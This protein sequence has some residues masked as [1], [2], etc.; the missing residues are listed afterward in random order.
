[1]LDMCSIIAHTPY[2]ILLNEEMCVLV[3]LF[4]RNLLNIYIVGSSQEEID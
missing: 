1:M 2:F 4:I 3:G